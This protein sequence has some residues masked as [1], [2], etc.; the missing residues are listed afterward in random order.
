MIKR[1]DFLKEEEKSYGRGKEQRWEVKRRGRRSLYRPP[2]EH[3]RI[4]FVK[5]KKTQIS[6]EVKALT[7]FCRSKQEENDLLRQELY[8][9]RIVEEV[10]K[11]WKKEG[12][13]PLND[14]HLQ[15]LPHGLVLSTGRLWWKGLWEGI[16]VR[17]RKKLLGT[18]GGHYTLSHDPTLLVESMKLFQRQISEGHD[19]QCTIKGQSSAKLHNFQL[20]VNPRKYRT[21]TVRGLATSGATSG[22]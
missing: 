8:E 16:Y 9:R 19:S 6:Q 14:F 20:W 13:T 22:C 11:E 7:E 17:Q 5:K 2:P 21:T 15:Y 3:F 18:N 12:L 4:D 1:P 10:E